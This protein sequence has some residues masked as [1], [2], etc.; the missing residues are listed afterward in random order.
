MEMAAVLIP[1]YKNELSRSEQISLQQCKR[2]LGRYPVI[3]IAPQTM[4][5]ENRE[6]SGLHVERFPQSFFDGISGYNR[7]MLSREFYQRFER[8][9]Y[10]LIY[11]L[12]AFVF[13]DRLQHFCELGYDYI[14][15][16]WLQGYRYITGLERRYLHV[17]NG[18]F[19]LRKVNAFLEILNDETVKVI[20]EPEDIFWSSCKRLNIAPVETAISFSFEAQVRKS[21]ELN[22]ESLPFGCHAWLNYDFGFLRPYIQQYGY[23]LNYVVFCAL[24][25][26]DAAHCHMQD[27]FDADRE[28]I[29]EAL[30]V[31]VKGAD[32]MKVAVFGVGNLGNQCYKILRY[33]G[34]EIAYCI[35][36]DKKKQGK[37]L[38]E[39]K[40]ISFE[41]FVETGEPEKTIIIAAMGRKHYDE[42]LGQMSRLSDKYGFHSIKYSDLYDEVVKRLDVENGGVLLKI[43]VF[44]VGKFYNN[45]KAQLAS[46]RNIEI[47]AFADN[48]ESLWGS[49]LDGCV[50]VAPQDIEKIQHD[51]IVIMSTY[52]EEIYGQLIG[53]GVPWERIR[54]WEV[55]YTEMA[56]GAW[57]TFRGKNDDGNGRQ[58]IL[59]ISTDLNYNGGSLAAA[60]A[61]MAL[62]AR[63]YN[64]AL[65]APFGDGKFINE[66]IGN[67]ITVHICPELPYICN[68]EWMRHF[69][70]VVVNVF[71][72]MHSAVRISR[73]RPVLWWIHESAEIFDETRLRYWN[74]V[75][76]S[77]LEDID[78]RAVSRVP[79]ENFN[80]FYPD[81]VQKILHYGIPDMAAEKRM[82]DIGKEKLIFAIVGN[83]CARK[84]QDIFCKAVQALNDSTR[85]EFWI[86]GSCGEDAFCDEVYGMCS[87]TDSLKMMG[88]LTR[89]GIYHFLPEID[90]IVCASR[91]DPLPIVMTEGMMFGKVCITT[92]VTGTADFIREGENGFVIPA[93]DVD[94]LKERMEWIL[95]NK[96]RLAGIGR[97][98]RKTYEQ[99]FSMEVFGE[100][101]DKALCEAEREWYLKGENDN[102]EGV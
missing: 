70:A 97:N 91:E 56:S 85:A 62:K 81:R 1:V 29:L 42:V 32:E 69:D 71:Q 51:M 92:D 64:A 5:I 66:L 67:G 46:Y 50:V 101:L 74:R 86:V 75:M 21:F 72:M 36:N 100:N 90:V 58:S 80:R 39:N 18:G 54:P 95:D 15:A 83:V 7:L 53:L 94:A 60:Y 22:Q 93:D 27:C 40:I 102:C 45:R 77:S 31:F 19:S 61:V 63:G 17:G 35:D 79:K 98:A 57:K 49:S 12:D 43:I 38:W 33:A 96:D 84:A 3:L 44:G 14:G 23:E 55:F 59:V 8:Y 87:Q 34:V 37:Y 2:I 68:M 20:D 82:N 11:Q 41:Q 76:Q 65:A 47:V 88:L 4:K 24:D 89:D 25:E 26:A 30:G 10:I 16:P 73:V 48:K 6:L 13:S 28:T 52:G 99:Y 9:E 78:I